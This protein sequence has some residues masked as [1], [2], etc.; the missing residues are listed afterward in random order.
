MSNHC[1]ELFGIAMEGRF[2]IMFCL[3]VQISI[4][5][6]ILTLLN[7]YTIN[8]PNFQLLKNNADVEILVHARSWFVIDSYYH[9]RI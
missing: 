2:G 3:R 7:H 8:I 6:L 9:S 1:A 4:V 5:F